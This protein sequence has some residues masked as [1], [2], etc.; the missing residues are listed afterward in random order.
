M[1]ENGRVEFSSK[2]RNYAITMRATTT[3]MINSQVVRQRGKTL[4]FK[5]HR[6]V[7]SDPEEI[8][9]LKGNDRYGIDFFLLDPGQ[10]SD[11]RNDVK[12]VRGPIGTGED[13]GITSPAEVTTPKQRGRKPKATTEGR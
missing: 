12:M 8:E 13:D 10:L 5:D 2:V 4:N 6:L 9:F 11:L 7:T 3:I 1:T